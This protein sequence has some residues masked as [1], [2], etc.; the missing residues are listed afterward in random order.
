[1]IKQVCIGIVVAL[2]LAGCGVAPTDGTRV[3]EDAGYTDV[4]IGGA[5]ILFSGC[6]EGDT[7]KSSFTA[8]SIATG[9]AVTGSLCQGWFKGITIRVN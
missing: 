9:R 1:M 3:L 7:F 5:E 8:K 2:A 6:G 4:V